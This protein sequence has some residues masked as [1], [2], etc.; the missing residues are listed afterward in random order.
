MSP[1]YLLLPSEFISYLD[2]KNIREDKNS[3]Y[4]SSTYFRHERLKDIVL[5]ID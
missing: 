5:D 3:R 1:L 4:N 2:T